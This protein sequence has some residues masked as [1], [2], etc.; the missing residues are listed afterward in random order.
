MNF[1]KIEFDAHV[2]KQITNTAYLLKVPFESNYDGY[3][4]WWPSRW[5]RKSEKANYRIL[6][7]KDTDK[8][9]FLLFDKHPTEKPIAINKIVVDAEEFKEIF[10]WFLI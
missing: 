7:F 4:F 9:E 1:N 8:F 2:V 6:M 5:I 10:K 3:V